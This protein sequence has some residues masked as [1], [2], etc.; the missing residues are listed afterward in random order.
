M[1]Y[2]VMLQDQ[3]DI[4]NILEQFKFLNDETHMASG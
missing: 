1:T 3:G 4:S 2:C